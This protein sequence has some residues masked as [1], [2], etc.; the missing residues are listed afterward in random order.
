MH[1]VHFFSFLQ[2]GSFST[3]SLSFR[4][5]QPPLY[6]NLSCPLFSPVIHRS[7]PFNSHY[8]S[9]FPILHP[10]SSPNPSFHANDSLLSASFPPHTPSLL[11]SLS[12]FF[13][14]LSFF[15]LHSFYV[16]PFPLTPFYPLH[17]LL[18]LL[19]LFLPIFPI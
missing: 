3:H 13:F 17:F 2:Q 7:R 6:F 5:F 1:F 4:S 11:S 10:Y 15:V 16:L 12:L 19:L 14:S 18:T 9:S 8:P